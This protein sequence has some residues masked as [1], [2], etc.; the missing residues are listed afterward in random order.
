MN[1]RVG[2]DLSVPI[3]KLGFGTVVV[4]KV[5]IQK[6]R[7][8]CRY[9]RGITSK[10]VASA[11]PHLS[12]WAAQLPKKRCSGCVPLATLCRFDRPGNRTPDLPHL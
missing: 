7:S 3:V 8:I 10:R 12:A 2:Q 4:C 11:S 6:I 1:L 5:K 9:A